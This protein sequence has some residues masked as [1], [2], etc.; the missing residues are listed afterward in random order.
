MFGLVN[1]QRENS[2]RVSLAR[3]PIPAQEGWKLACTSSRH[4]MVMDYQKKL[5]Q[6]EMPPKGCITVCARQPVLTSTDRI[7]LE[8][9]LSR[10]QSL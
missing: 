3:L 4:Q 1:S 10:A 7:N 2:L 5:A 8:D 6:G 9:Y